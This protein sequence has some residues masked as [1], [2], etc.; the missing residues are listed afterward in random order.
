MFQKIKAFLFK[1]QTLRQTVIKN[2]FWL[3]G[4]EISSR[5]LRAA[6]VI[7]AARVLGAEGW[8]VFSYA[9]TLAAFFTIFSDIGLSALITREAAKNPQLRIKYFSTAFFIKLVLMFFS[10]SLIILLAPLFTKIEDIKTLLPI[11]ALILVFDG[12]REFG[13]SFNRA[14]EK[15]E[16]EALVKI[17]TNFSIAALG[18][19]FLIVATTARSLAIAYTIG[20]ATGFLAIIWVLRPYFR[21]LFS[22]FT[23]NLLWPIFSSAWPFALL[24]FLG[25]IM[26][27]T[28]IIMLGWF[29]TTQEV[30]F[31]SAVQRPIQLFYIIPALLATAIFPTFSRLAKK[32][33]D[34]FRQV[35]EKSLALVLLL[36]I[37][38]VFGGVIL[39]KEIIL[40][41]FGSQYLSST[42]AFQILLPTILIIFPSALI[43][44]AIF[45]YDEQKKFIG[46]LALGALSNVALNYFLIPLYGIGGAAI[47]TVGAQFLANGF[48][49]F[50]MKKINHFSV[51]P[52]LK[53]IL[54]A[55]GIM[56]TATFILK[57][58]EINFFVNLITSSSIYFGSLIILKEL[59]L[60]EIKNIINLR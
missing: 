47:A 43:G 38:L 52:H 5:L 58:L 56:T 16:W 54:L 24:G 6:I 9:I 33:N 46:F 35:L 21:N 57:H 20:S 19:I 59:I 7:Y 18:F 22:N 12:L 11:V 39:G 50:K 8:G 27:N 15:M 48:V 55:T 29:R 17:L 10:V 51:F 13:F 2:T 26:I 23:K 1:N 44:N 40:T 36:G 32:D 14:L 31:Y 37:P 45:A 60:K 4:G 3:F 28:D 30:G 49:W 53:K 42:I 25:S 34:K 41:I